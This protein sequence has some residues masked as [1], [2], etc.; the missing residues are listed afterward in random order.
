MRQLSKSRTGCS[1]CSAE[2]PLRRAP[3]DT[4]TAHVQN[5]LLRMVLGDLSMSSVA[6]DRLRGLAVL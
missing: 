2:V 4:A 5:R 1:A 6:R 3:T